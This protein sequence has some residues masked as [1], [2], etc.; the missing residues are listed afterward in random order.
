MKDGI[1]QKKVAGVIQEA[2]TE[3]FQKMNLSVIGGGLMSISSVE[4]TPDLSVARVRLS[5]YNIPDPQQAIDKMQVGANEIRFQLGNKI[6]NQVRHVPNLEFF[7]DD[8]L[9]EVFRIEELLRNL[10]K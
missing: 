9:D 10:K 4:M 6:K 2:L 3:I 7:R 5:F 1:R 8:S